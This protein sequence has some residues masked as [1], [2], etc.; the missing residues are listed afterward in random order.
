MLPPVPRSF[1]TSGPCHPARDYMLPAMAR[2]P[3]VRGLVERGKYFVI[4][5]PRQ[6]GKTTAVSALAQE[7]TDTGNHVAAVV[8]VEVGSAMRD[9]IGAAELAILGAWRSSA[10]RRLPADLVPPVWR[11]APPGQRLNAALQAWAQAMPKPLVLFLDEIDSLEGVVLVS[12]LRQI[13]DGFQDRP[14]SFPWSLALVGMRDVR[15]YKIA[16]D[17]RDGAVGGSPFNIKDRSLLLRDFTRDEVAA[18]YAQHTDDTGQAFLPEAVDRAFAL[19]NGQPWLTNALAAVA[20]DELVVDRGRPILPEHVDQ[21]REVLIERRDTH[22]DSLAERLRDPRIRAI[23]EPM[24]A[25]SSPGELQP[26]DIRLATDLG[27][28]RHSTMGGLEVANPIYREIIVRELAVP[29]R[30][31][32]PAIAPTWLT[33]EGRLDPTR[34]LEAFVAFWR[35]HGEPLLSTSPYHEIAP[36]L[37]L[38][39]FLHRVVNGGGSIEREYAIGRGRMDLCVRYGRDALAIELKVWRDRQPDPITEGLAQLDRYLAGL[40]LSSGWLVIFD[41]RS[42]LAPIAER[43][44]VE[45]RDTPTGRRVAVIRA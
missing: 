2:L 4:H 16:L 15:D 9:D 7:L 6:T 20:V 45:D 27:L 35:Q 43:T 40:G 19:T 34:L 23:V 11:D 12:V 30:A 21:A 31:A 5:A 10:E 25:G 44:Q 18:L 33:P 26:D 24:L 8:S 29:A 32:L 1:N 3:E 41:R 17:G 36:H 28:L 37:V 38:M 22:L 14:A 39:A 13:R 42:G